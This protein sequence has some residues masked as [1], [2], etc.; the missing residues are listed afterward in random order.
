MRYQII[1]MKM[2]D[3]K[4]PNIGGGAAAVCIDVVNDSHNAD[5]ARAVADGGDA[6]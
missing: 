3:F 5:Q 1:Y 2:A 6:I 4:L